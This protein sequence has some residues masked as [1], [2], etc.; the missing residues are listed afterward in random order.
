M[1]TWE[2]DDRAPSLYTRMYLLGMRLMRDKLAFEGAQHTLRTARKLQRRGSRP[3]TRWTRLTTRL[4][5]TAISGMP[6]W[7]VASPRSKPTVRVVYVHGGGYVHPLTTDYCR[8]VRALAR[9]P[10]KCSCRTTRSPPTPPSTTYCPG[11]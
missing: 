2:K 9:R 1:L 4:T 5:T 6:V 11:S 10:L 8:L 3:P 7:T